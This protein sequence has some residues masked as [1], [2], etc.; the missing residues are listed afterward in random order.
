[1][2]RIAVIIRGMRG[3]ATGQTQATT[4]AQTL[5]IV[6]DNGQT[7]WYNMWSY[8]Y[9]GDA[10]THGDVRSDVVIR[11]PR[12]AYRNP[13]RHPIINPERVL[14]NKSCIKSYNKSY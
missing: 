4:I 1:M 13:I 12:I 7:T 14:H 3:W 11:D 6:S 9:V 10:G 5:A 2:K 8:V